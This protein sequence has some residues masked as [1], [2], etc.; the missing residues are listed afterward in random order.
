MDV[1][2]DVP[3]ISKCPIVAVVINKDILKD[4]AFESMMEGQIRNDGI[5]TASTMPPWDKDTPTFYTYAY[6]EADDNQAENNLFTSQ[7]AK[8][9]GEQLLEKYFHM[10]NFRFRD[11]IGYR[12]TPIRP[13]TNDGYTTFHQLPVAPY[14]MAGDQLFEGIPMLF[15]TMNPDHNRYYPASSNF[16]MELQSPDAW[17]LNGNTFTQTG[18]LYED[19]PLLPWSEIQ[20]VFEEQHLKT[21]KV[22]DVYGVEFGYELVLTTKKGPSTR[23]GNIGDRKT[24][25]EGTFDEEYHLRPVWVLRG[26]ES[27]SRAP[28]GEP[29]LEATRTDKLL[30]P[31]GS[32]PGIYVDAQTGEVLYCYS[33]NIDFS[34]N[35]MPTILTWDDVRKK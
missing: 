31:H 4:D 13:T 3:P 5:I 30:G 27:W 23:V 26:F 34:D 10:D 9:Y 24:Y 14:I 21:G 16:Y 11:V 32:V 8:A 25:P 1:L 18:I 15:S 22:L 2:I 6:P 12:S 28:G 33:A 17:Y 29:M 35:F 7:E 19:V 20:K